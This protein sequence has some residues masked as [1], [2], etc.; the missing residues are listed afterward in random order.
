MDYFGLFLPIIL[1]ILSVF[2]IRMRKLPTVLLMAG[3]ITAVIRLIMILPLNGPLS[4]QQRIVTV[5]LLGALPG[6]AMTGLSYITDKV[7]KGD[8]V[9]LIIMGLFE[10]C[11][12]VTLASCMACFGLAVFS[13]ILLVL[14]KAGRNT[15]MPFVPFLTAAYL[16]L[17]VSQRG[18]G[19]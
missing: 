11:F 8:G 10:N 7:G 19:Y 1:T 18:F 14:H 12:F 3:V 17:I 15:R 4:E 16:I 13:G 9:V 5:A 2:D 6:I